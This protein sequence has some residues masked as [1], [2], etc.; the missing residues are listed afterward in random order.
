MLR[1]L[2]QTKARESSFNLTQNVNEVLLPAYDAL[3]DPFLS[4]YFDNP[5]LKRHL[6]KTGVI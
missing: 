4:G 1:K 2:H 5:L 6:K 3:H